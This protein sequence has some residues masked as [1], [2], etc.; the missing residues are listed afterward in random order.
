M[1]EREEFDFW[2]G[3]YRDDPRMS[4]AETKRLLLDMCERGNRL[5]ISEAARLSPGDVGES[6]DWEEAL[7][8]LRDSLFVEPLAAEEGERPDWPVHIRAP[9]DTDA[10]SAD[11]SKVATHIKDARHWRCESCK[12]ELAGSSLLM[13]HHIDRNKTNNEPGNLQ[14]LCA[15]CHGSAHLGPPLWPTGWREEEKEALETHQ[16]RIGHLR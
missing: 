10:Y 1:N 6:A 4:E 5:A 3:A 13:V 7:S 11:W 16:R 9:S 8:Q 15:I 2:I 14:V 12:F